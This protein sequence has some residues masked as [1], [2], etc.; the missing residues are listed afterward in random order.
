MQ[1]FNSDIL[2]TMAKK[3]L[4]ISEKEVLQTIQEFAETHDDVII[5]MAEAIVRLRKKLSKACET[6]YYGIV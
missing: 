5:A 3:K 4:P 1:S 6:R 2:R